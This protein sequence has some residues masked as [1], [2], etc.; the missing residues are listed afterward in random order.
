MIPKVGQSWLLLRI[1]T[2]SWYLHW[3]LIGIHNLMYNNQTVGVAL[4]SIFLQIFSLPE[5]TT[6][7]SILLLKPNVWELSLIDL[8]SSS[9]HPNHPLPSKCRQKSIYFLSIF[10]TTSLAKAPISFYPEFWNSLWD[11]L[12]S[13]SLALLQQKLCSIQS[14]WCLRQ[15]PD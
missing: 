11:I 4:N 10:T 8:F 9:L 3:W 6:M 12:L 14:E 2:P 5:W 7:S 13:L 1:L 15:K